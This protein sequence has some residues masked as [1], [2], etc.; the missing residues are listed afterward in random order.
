MVEIFSWRPLAAM[1]VSALA[2]PLIV[3]SGKRPNLRET[4]TL[5]AAFAKWGL[6]VSMLPLV[7]GGH[8]TGHDPF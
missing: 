7:L 2:I 1:A 6:V 3:A 5:L 8:A 4:W